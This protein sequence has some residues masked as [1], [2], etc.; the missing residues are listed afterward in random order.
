MHSDTTSGLF[1]FE[2]IS[3]DKYQ[4]TVITN[5]NKVQDDLRKR[6]I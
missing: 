1:S 2:I 4:E 3:E 6:V 5:G